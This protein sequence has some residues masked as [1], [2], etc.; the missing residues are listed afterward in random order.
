MTCIAVLTSSG[1]RKGRAIAD[2]AHLKHFFILK[3]LVLAFYRFHPSCS[4][5]TFVQEYVEYMRIDAFQCLNVFL[6]Y[7]AICG[8]Y[9][10]FFKPFSSIPCKTN[11]TSTKQYKCSRLRCCERSTSSSIS[12]GNWC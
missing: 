5:P 11:Q 4:F 6:H 1:H 12:S 3:F 9:L 10:L 7:R 2:P 8:S